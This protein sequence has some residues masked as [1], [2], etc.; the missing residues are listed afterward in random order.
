MSK[1]GKP[2]ERVVVAVLQTF[3]PHA[4]VSQGRWI[5]ADEGRLNGKLL[6]VPDNDS[7]IIDSWLASGRY[8]Q[9]A[10]IFTAPDS[11]QQI[12]RFAKLA[13]TGLTAKISGSVTSRAGSCDC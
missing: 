11:V 13:P 6:Q 8:N 3:D 4:S 10:K 7:G 2:Y 1:Q 12:V 5:V 9:L